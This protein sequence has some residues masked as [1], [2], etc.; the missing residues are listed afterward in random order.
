MKKI[1]LALLLLYFQPSFSQ[2]TLPNFDEIKLD[3]KSDYQNADPSALQ[4]A[5]YI[6][7]TAFNKDDLNRLKSLQFIIKWMSGTPDYIFSLDNVASKI[8]KG[9]DDL[10]GLYMACMTNKTPARLLRE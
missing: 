10:L 3:Q 8:I 9:N 7:S 4:A 2:T 6:L 5:N 1:M